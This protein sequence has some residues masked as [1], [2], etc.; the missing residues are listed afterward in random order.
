SISFLSPMVSPVLP[1]V[2][3]AAR[4]PIRVNTAT[5]GKTFKVSIQFYTSNDSTVIGSVTGEEI[6][7]SGSGYQATNY[8]SV[9]GIAP[10]NAARAR[11]VVTVAGMASGEYINIDDVYLTSVDNRY[12]ELLDFATRSIEE[13]PGRWVATD[14]TLSRSVGFLYVGTGYYCLGVTS[15]IAS[16]AIY[17][18]TLSY[19]P[20]T[21]GRTYV[22]Y[23]ATQAPGLTLS[24]IAGIEWYAADNSLI[25]TSTTP[26][27]YSQTIVR[28]ACSGTAP[29][30]AVKAR[31]MARA[32]VTATGQSF[33]LDDVSLLA[34]KTGPDGDGPNLLTYE[35]WST[36]TYL[37]AWTVDGGTVQRAYFTSPITDGFY[38]LKLTP[39][40]PGSGVVTARL[41]RLIPATPGT[42]YQVGATAY[43]HNTDTSQT[44]TSAMRMT[45]DWYDSNGNLF[46]VDNPDQ[47]YPMDSSAEWYA[48]VNTETRTCPEGAAYARVA[49][50][51]DSS[52]PLIDFWSADTIFLTE[53]VSEYDLISDNSTGCI[54]LVVNYVPASSANSNFVT[55]KRIDQDGTSSPMR[56]YG[57]TWDFA[58]N[59]YSPLV[60]EDYEAP[61]GSRV[62][63]SVTW[64]NASG[65]T[66][67]TRIFTR[68]IDAPILTDPDFVWFKSPG[69]PALN[70]LV[71]ME[72]PLSWA[73]ASRTARY[74]IVGR[75]NP[76]H[77]TGAR[78]GRTSSITVLVWDP[79]A[80]ELFN[81]LLDAGTPAL[82]Q[83]MPGYG[84]DGNLYVAV[85]DVEVEPLDPDAR[86]DG[87]RWTLAIT[88]V[89]RPEGGLQGSAGS[90]WEDILDY[91]TWEQVFNTYDTW[92]D[93]L[94]K[95]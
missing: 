79:D 7:L 30:G 84:I 55:I 60:V 56:A 28:V 51:V 4:V 53:A 82:I 69:I 45:I 54:T 43:R 11:L 62:W 42:T 78:A 72:A 92:A 13:G 63:Y 34:P 58:P 93:V 90:T 5:A 8:A 57:R 9:S 73:R 16:G 77:I 83:A 17:A 47:F 61:L 50:E 35:E 21:E 36:E 95:G 23:A 68:T 29:V 26:T 6:K 12:G 10:S 67:A 3:Y 1:N 33:Y 66:I 2:T 25:S 44:I 14:A 49:I 65:T 87:W 64:S 27:E 46:Q 39:A 31:V 40:V 74:D 48:M 76:I 37:P 81:S 20:V 86:E 85:G 71:M 38:A 75:K 70:T 22:M 41:D 94:I 32:D 59:P 91:P 52:N 80:N 24:G 15:T 18:R 88:E 19:Y 89:D